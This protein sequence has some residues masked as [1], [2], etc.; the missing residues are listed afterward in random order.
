MAKERL[1]KLQKYIL[2]EALELSEKGEL[3]ERK[4]IYRDF[5]NLTSHYSAFTPYEN[6]EHSRKAKSAYVSVGRSLKRLQEKGLV[7]FFYRKYNGE[8]I[9]WQ[10]SDYFIGLTEEGK[11]R[12]K[13]LN[14]KSGII[15]TELN[16]KN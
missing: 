3:L 9:T 15:D 2:T 13:S 4:S 6:P 1:S 12:A 14:A 5:F 11:A 10:W 16:I 7:N 8:Y